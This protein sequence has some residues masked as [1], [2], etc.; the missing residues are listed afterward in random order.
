VCTSACDRS[1]TRLSHASQAKEREEWCGLLRQPQPMA[2]GGSRQKT[3]MRIHNERAQCRHVWSWAKD[4]GMRRGG[5]LSRQDLWEPYP[6]ELCVRLELVGVRLA[7][8]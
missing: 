7:A 3:A 2:G 8:A 4:S 5:I 6:P 1:D